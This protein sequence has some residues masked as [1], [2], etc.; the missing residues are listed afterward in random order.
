MEKE[1]LHKQ[2]LDKNKQDF[3][4]LMKSFKSMLINLGE[5]SLA[6]RLP[7]VGDSAG[8]A[9]QSGEA[10]D[11]LLQAI[12]ISFQLLNLVEQNNSTQLRRQMETQLGPAS[13]RGSWAETLALL[14]QDYTEDH[15]AH[16]IGRLNVMPVLTAHPTEAKRVTVL[17]IHRELYQ[18]LVKKENP[19]WS[20]QEQ[21][22][23]HQKITQILERWWRT[24][25]TYLQKPELADE[26]SNLIHYFS[27]VFPQALA[28]FDQRFQ[29]SW[30]QAGFD[31]QR[32]AHAHQLPLLQLGSWVGGDRDGHPFV[33][34]EFTADTLRHHRSVALQ[35][36]RDSL[37]GLAKKI[38]L[39]SRLAV[40]P[41]DFME[42][43]EKTAALFEQT[44]AEALKR[45]P[46]EP[47]R[48]FANLM[49]AKMSNTLN[50]DHGDNPDLYY[51]DAS[52]LLDDL[53]VMEQ[54]LI[55]IGAQQINRELVFPLQRQ[56]HCFGFHLAKLDIRQNSA[57]HDQA[58]EEILTA[59]GHQNPNFG[60]WSESERLTFINQEL[61]SKRPFLP[62]RYACGE[63]AD[64]VLGYFHALKTHC[65][66]FGY[67][68]IGSIIVSMT[69]SLSDLL[70]V[71][72]FLRE[73]GLND[74][75]FQVVPLLETIDDLK[76]GETI[77]DH[78]LSHP[79]TQKRLRAQSR[80]TQEIMLG[81]SDSNK[82]G[83]IIASRWTIYKSEIQLTQIAQRHQVELCFFHGRGGTISRGGGKIH[84]F[85]DSMPPGSVS[86][87]IKMT[88]QGE[89]IANQF[90]NLLN[91][92]QN[93]EIFM[94]GTAKQAIKTDT[95]DEFESAYPLLEELVS[96]SQSTY[97]NLLDHPD[98]IRF[99]SAAT[100]IDI[101]EQSKIGSRPA[102]RSGKRSLNDLRSIP[103]VFSWSQARFNLTGWFGTG[104]ALTYL[105]GD[106]NN[107]TTLCH[108]ADKWPFFKY[109]LIQIETNMLDAD[110]DIM[111]QFAALETD[112]TLSE[113]ML[114]LILTDYKN[115]REETNNILANP[116]S[117]R[118]TEKLEDAKLRKAALDHLHQLQLYYLRLYR[119]ANNEDPIKDEL[120]NHLL[121]TVNALAGGLK[122]TG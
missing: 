90:A 34:A 30:Q 122:S 31:P 48:Q 83:G 54:S 12:S 84:R 11:R 18:L 27:K 111:K 16:M 67:Q 56:V 47:W 92:T 1:K 45:N 73:V 101:L 89:T 60:Q 58:L 59:S 79:I 94:A 23:I 63:H 36:H 53:S 75:P 29:Y 98:F 110:P 87:H 78:Y 107:H 43:L 3:L 66:Q 97:R 96:R 64:N 69:R 21:A 41:K 14:Q 108:L 113:N 85:M 100:P 80:P 20:T 68:G 46:S 61:K 71:Y 42:Q 118:R 28:L 49:T 44:G 88:I 52:A 10:D 72:L 109:L 115:A 51:K 40:I 117:Q 91:A 37:Q 9:S 22:A 6:A 57:Y 2:S 15:I 32:F 5:T 19:T 13:I 4:Y 120:L 104:A 81:Y 65:D 119:N 74:V 93:L 38:S 35:L 55:A 121:I 86:G 116:L 26:R 106:S 7:W 24:G 105:M 70:V 25:E 33:T 99:Y 62:H 17:E 102:R 82:D 77:L 50:G 8:N 114:N 39:S 76:A 103:W 95:V 112:Q